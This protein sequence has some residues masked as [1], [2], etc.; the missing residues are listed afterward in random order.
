MSSASNDRVAFTFFDYI[1]LGLILVAVEAPGRMLIFDDHP[2]TTRILVGS[3][4]TL[5]L[6]ALVLYFSKLSN[7][8]KPTG[9]KPKS[10][11]YWTEVPKEPSI[12]A[13]LLEATESVFD[14]LVDTIAWV[15]FAVI[16]VSIFTAIVIP[17]NPKKGV[18]LDPSDPFAITNDAISRC[19]DSMSAS[20]NC[21]ND[22][23]IKEGRRWSWDSKTDQLRPL[24]R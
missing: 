21:V 15:F 11:T 9:P 5:L 19:A 7:R 1:G 4:I 3:G 2:V 13:R 22:L 6:G 12:V 24:K 16:I 14:F 17:S 23:L 10:K 18:A 20:E 8:S